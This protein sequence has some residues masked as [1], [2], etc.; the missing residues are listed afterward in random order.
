[1]I[2]KLAKG[3]LE[4]AEIELDKLAAPWSPIELS[5]KL[6]YF[7]EIRIKDIEIKKINNFI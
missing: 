3:H 4:R 2:E 7:M 6:N 1:L 5:L